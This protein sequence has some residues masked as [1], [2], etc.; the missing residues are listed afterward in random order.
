M[1]YQ[2]LEMKMLSKFW[3]HSLVIYRNILEITT[4][5]CFCIKVHFI[6]EG[7]GV[8]LKSLQL[9]RHFKCS[10]ISCVA[11]FLPIHQKL[12]PCMKDCISPIKTHLLVL[13]SHQWIHKSH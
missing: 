8:S 1:E 7:Y 4:Y 6:C 11:R 9:Q 13:L 2:F 5:K 10:C 12:N 3:D